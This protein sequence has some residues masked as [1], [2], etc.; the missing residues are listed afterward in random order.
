MERK[1]HIPENGREG[2]KKTDLIEK[3]CVPFSLLSILDL[4]G[5]EQ[6]MFQISMP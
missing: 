6:Q 5:F 2:E 1:E 3:N 4:L